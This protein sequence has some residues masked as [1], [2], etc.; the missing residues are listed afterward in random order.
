MIRRLALS[1]CLVIAPAVAVAQTDTTTSSFEVNG[2]KVY[3]YRYKDGGPI[4]I[5]VMAQDVKKVKPDA[6][7]E[8]V[9]GKH[10][11]VDYSKL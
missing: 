1:F 7:V 5:G 8:K 9:D 10:D 2:L 6:V 4:H 11:A 3:K